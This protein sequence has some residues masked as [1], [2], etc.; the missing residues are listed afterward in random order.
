MDGRHQQKRFQ[1]KLR[2]P[3]WFIFVCAQ[4]HAQ[5]KETVLPL[6][7]GLEPK[8]MIRFITLKPVVAIFDSS[9]FLM[10]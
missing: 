6:L 5:I 9:S 3:N 2:H 4:H 1:V 10:Y 8:N 7:S